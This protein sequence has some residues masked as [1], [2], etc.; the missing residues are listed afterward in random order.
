M[1]RVSLI[2]FRLL[3]LQADYSSKAKSTFKSHFQDAREIATT[4]QIQN[5][6][7][8]ILGNSISLVTK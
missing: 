7:N 3:K 8:Q 4:K 6:V 2:S 5:C 1:I